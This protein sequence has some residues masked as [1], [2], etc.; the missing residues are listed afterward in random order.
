MSLSLRDRIRIR[1]GLPP[2]AEPTPI[3]PVSPF[4]ADQRLRDAEA[5]CQTYG[6]LVELR[7]DGAPS[8]EQDAAAVRVVIAWDRWMRRW[9]EA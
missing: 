5:V 8:V 7:Q 1:Q 4:P 2:L 9:G 3:R 6:R